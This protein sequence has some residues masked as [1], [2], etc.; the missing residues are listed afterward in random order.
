M[1]PLSRVGW[2]CKDGGM[3]EPLSIIGVDVDKVGL[4]R[5]DG[6]RGSGLYAVPIKL[7]RPPVPREAALLLHFWDNPRTWST[8]HRSGIARI[9]DDSIVLD[10]TTVDEVRDVHAAT[11]RGIVAWTNEAYEK[12]QE[13]EAREREAEQARIAEHESNVRRTAAEIRFD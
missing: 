5:N 9:Q 12:E 2:G 3:F 4:P 7:S 13:L 8:M 10:G 11:V 1:E 6:T